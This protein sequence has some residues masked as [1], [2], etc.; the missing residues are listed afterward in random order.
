MKLIL[1]SAS[2]RRKELLEQI[3]LAF[4]IIP[5]DCEEICC[6][7]KPEE[8]VKDLARQKAENVAVK[9]AELIK[10]HKISLLPEEKAVVLGSDTV[11]AMEGE[12]L[13]KPKDGKEAF[14]MIQRLQGKSH[15][16]YSG[17]A[18]FVLSG[19]MGAV[20][21]I[22]NFYV[23]TQV[24]VYS[25]T[26]E[27]IQTYIATGEPMD[28]AGAYGIQGRFAEYIKGITGDYYNV[29]GLPVSRVMRELK[30]I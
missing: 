30:N 18:L 12:I 21:D 22:R 9:V 11:V 16:V 14:Q 8:L 20:T 28:K 19:D 6:L 10:K 5:S 27:E 26:K 17:V 1:A 25:M 23:K 2:P 24:E 7:D 29:V 3:G 15:Q 13:G 4:Q